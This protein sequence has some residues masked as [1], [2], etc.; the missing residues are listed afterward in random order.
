MSNKSLHRLT[1]AFT[2]QML[3][4][5]GCAAPVTMQSLLEEMTDLASLAEYP[6][7]AFMCKQFSSYD[8][9]STSADDAVAW[10]ANADA[11]HYLRTE[12]NNGRTEHVMMDAAGPGA[13]VRIW[14]ANPKGTLRIYLDGKD[15]PALEA[16]MTELLGG[17]FA[18]IPGP[19]AGTR[20]RGWNSYF[21]IPYARHCKI[22]SDEG[23][24][25][26][27]VNYRTYSDWT[28]VETFR[29]EHL[30][31]LAPMI[32]E[33]TTALAQTDRVEQAAEGAKPHCGVHELSPGQRATVTREGPAAMNNLVIRVDAD[34]RDAALRKVVLR[35]RF[36]GRQTVE[37]PIGDFY[38]AAP[39][40]N[41]YTSLPL[42]VADDGTMWCRWL[43]PFRKRMEIEFENT[44]DQPVSIEADIETTPYRWTGDSMHFH[45]GWRF[46]GDVPTRPM[47]DWRY[48]AIE[49]RGVFVGASFTIANP[50]RHWWGEGDEKIYVDGERFPSHF[51]TGT[52]DY[53][54]Y[55]W[56]SNEP[57]THAYHN[58]PRCDGPRNYGYT[59]VNRW[60]ILD[61]IPFERNFR[62][63]MELWHWHA[64]CV[65]DLCVTTYWYAAPGATS[66]HRALTAA[67]LR[68]EPMPE[69]VPFRVPGAIEAEK[70]RIVEKTGEPGPQAIDGC[71]D[72]HHLWWRSAKPGDRLVLEFEAPN[73]GR[74]RVFARFVTAAD[75]GVHQLAINDTACAEMIDLHHDGIRVADERE[76]GIF[77]LSKGPNRLTAEVVG[78]HEKA[79]KSYMLGLDYIRIELVD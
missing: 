5:A 64:D 57:F 14:S 66:D 63:D 18:G 79:T 73:A 60:H 70:M 75:Y 38:G 77:S 74:F 33:T 39:G 28:T 50:V 78:A 6:R 25:Y 20:S 34:D 68:Y 65:V 10:F 48:V 47:Q 62:F 29:R 27:H 41:P 12:E 58:Q 19:I 44:S 61:R 23:G 7:P 13:I 22:T 31:E 53:F 11:G 76:L 24:F 4:L 36:D 43:M 32:R 42:G 16:P 15:T 35:V 51:G 55:A 71:S 49:G 1:T 54:G 3:L 67:D 9:A 21:P 59:S 26:Y 52:E 72:D 46:A 17:K 40:L 56:C 2:F 69:Y 37:A 45:A 8:R 30:S